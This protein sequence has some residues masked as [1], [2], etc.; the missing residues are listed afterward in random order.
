MQKIEY[1]EMNCESKEKFNI[2]VEINVLVNKIPKSLIPFRKT[3][4]FQSKG[5]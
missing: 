1:K 5:K 3:T 4:Y 2:F